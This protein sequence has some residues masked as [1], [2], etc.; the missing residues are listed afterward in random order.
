MKKIILIYNY[1]SFKFNRDIDETLELSIN[2][3]NRQEFLMRKFKDLS[4]FLIFI[5]NVKLDLPR[6]YF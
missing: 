1:K 6:R 4:G 5:F 3:D 2:S